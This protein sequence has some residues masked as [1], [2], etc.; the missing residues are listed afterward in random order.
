MRN[1]RVKGLN[2][3]T[4]KI[5]GLRLFFPFFFALILCPLAFSLS[6]YAAITQT[7][8]YQGF[9]LSKLTN[10][11]VETPQDIKFVI[12]DAA[13]AGSALFTET[14]CNVQV[15]KG[16][17][18][19]EIGSAAGGITP[20][21]IFTDY[22]GVWLEIQV[23]GNGDCLPPFEPMSPR[24]RLQASPF[25]F[26][27]LYASTASAA[28]TIFAADTIA[29]LPQ[30]AYGAITI[31]TNLFVQGDISVGNISA[32]QKLAVAGM[33]ESSTGGFKFPDG[34]VQIKA[35]AITMWDVNGPNLYTINPGNIG[36]GEALLSPLARLHISSAA[37]DA[38]NL[39]LISTGASQLFLV[40]G[41]GQVY[42]GSYYGDGATLTGILRKAGD[43]MTGQLTLA[44]SS[45]TVTSA[46]GLSSPKLKLLENVEIS[47]APASAYG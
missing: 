35:A 36:I 22:N 12:Y 15:N 41:L 25:A 18:D 17:Y 40:N 39:L 2:Q 27:S 47:S 29:A 26:N 31:S 46:L 7:I 13:S 11:P 42:G 19:I 28:T 38:G 10:L 32:G 8:N 30:T 37:G 43:T 16:R 3:K 5:S 24:I 45:L 14:R 44:A 21:S 6:A 20:A 1:V 34:S 23:D 33:V 4:G 9:L